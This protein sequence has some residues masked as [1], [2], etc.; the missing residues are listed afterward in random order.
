MRGVESEMV[1]VGGYDMY[2]GYRE[3]DNQNQIILRFIEFGDKKILQITYHNI[4]NPSGHAVTDNG[5]IHP[6]G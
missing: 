5:T 4:N 1:Y 2:I 3:D 6:R